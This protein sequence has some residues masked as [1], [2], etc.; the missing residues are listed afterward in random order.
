[1]SVK[2][3]L[4]SIENNYPENSFV[5]TAVTSFDGPYELMLRA[6]FYGEHY[7]ERGTISEPDN[8][9]TEIDSIVYFDLEFNYFSTG[10]CSS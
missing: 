7:D 2:E 1:M 3:L 5:A 6:N 8:P 4:Y 9:T 10:G